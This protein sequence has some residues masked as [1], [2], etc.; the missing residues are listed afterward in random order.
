M[1]IALMT[2]V[3]LFAGQL[4][5]ETLGNVEYHLPKQG[6]AWKQL[7]ELQGSKTVSSSTVIYVPENSSSSTA[8]ESFAVHVNKIPT[9]ATDKEALKTGIEKGMS[10]TLDNPKATVNQLERS[11]RSALYEWS[12]SVGGIEKVHGWT[13]AIST[14]NE[15][16]MLTYQTEQL[17]KLDIARPVWIQVLKDA[18]L[19]GSN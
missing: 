7:K 9:D 13:R 6:M 8:D 10:L 12:V 3:C 4:A 1:R 5:A 16:I 18:K 11:A 2:M 19:S 15:T 17:K 14:P